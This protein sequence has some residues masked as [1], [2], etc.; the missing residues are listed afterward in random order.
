MFCPNCG[1]ENADGSTFCTSCGAS[2]GNNVAQAGS[3]APQPAFQPVQQ[4]GVQPMQPAQPVRQMSSSDSALRLVNFILCV[5]STVVCGLAI[6]PLAW[7][8][9]MTVH[10]WG[11]YK[12]KNRNTVAFGVCTLLFV[13]LSGGVLLLVSTKDD[14]I[15]V[16]TNGGY[17]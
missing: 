7:M 1:S 10:S 11:I 4:P 14:Y 12:G 15:L 17:Y 5:I 16:S 13:N 9:P 2:F 6:I 8:I 3:Y